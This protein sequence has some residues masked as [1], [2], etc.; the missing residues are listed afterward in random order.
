MS[1]NTNMVN[2][3]G[4][5]FSE[6]Q[7]QLLEIAE[8]FSRDKA[9]IAT[10]RSLIESE[11]GFDKDV[12]TEM[13]SLGWLGI[14]IPEEFGG[15][16]LTV[17]EVVT[18]VEPMGRM[19]LA[20]PLVSTTLAAQLLLDAGIDSQ[21]SDL[22][23]KI[24]GGAIAALAINEEH[25][26]W[27]VNHIDCTGVVSG[28]IVTLSGIKTL[29]TDAKVADIILA[30]I[31]IDD[32]PSVVVIDPAKV[33]DA[34]IQR[35]T[36]IDETRR[37]YRINLNG[38]SVPSANILDADRTAAALKRYHLLS[39]LLLSAESCGGTAG[40]M[41]ITLDYLNTRRTFDRFI[42]SYQSLKH[43]MVDILTGLE[44]ARSFL[45]YAAGVIDTDEGEAAVRMAKA[46]SSENFSYAGDRSIQFHGG[47]G[48]TY[49]CDAQLFRRRAF[50][51][52]NQSGDAIYHRKRLAT[53]LL[54]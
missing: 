29:V 50:W 44:A 11:T 2:N 35:E 17:A 31:T 18:I 54:D 37:S 42:G 7:A 47:F 40:A 12:W 41:D 36:I 22:L 30:T 48:F 28:D 53:L 38:I 1:E 16:G 10:V 4:I 43:T 23:P 34:A 14:A 51:T 49:E 27:D 3:T 15:S 39:C 21:K 9:P 52:T 25:G 6:E 13:A 46:Q 24:A 8:S 33:D 20:T 45:Y 5:T 26:D 32:R 19:L